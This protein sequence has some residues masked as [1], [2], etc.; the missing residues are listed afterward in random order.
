MSNIEDKNWLKIEV[1]S[2]QIEIN[3]TYQLKAWQVQWWSKV[4]QHCKQPFPLNG[5]HWFASP[6]ETAFHKWERAQGWA[7]DL[8]KRKWFLQSRKDVNRFPKVPIEGAINHGLSVSLHLLLSAL[9]EAYPQV[10]NV[11]RTICKFKM[12]FSCGGTFSN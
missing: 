6:S 4:S 11:E 8:Y 5:S 10:L 7:E 3:D 9:Y 2:S 1:R 12:Y